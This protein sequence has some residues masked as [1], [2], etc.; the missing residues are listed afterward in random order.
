LIA[1][2]L[3]SV[4]PASAASHG[5]NHPIHNASQRYLYVA[6]GGSGTID[7]L[8]ISPSGKV[9]PI[10][11]APFKLDTPLLPP[12]PGGI[13]GPFS[14]GVTP[15]GRYLYTA[16]FMS[17]NVSGFKVAANGGLSPVPG[18]PFSMKGISDV[19]VIS[20]NGRHV[21]VDTGTQIEGF[22]IAPNGS[23]V[24]PAFT[25]VP[26]DGG[27][28]GHQISI[29][30]DGRHVFASN[31]FANTITTYAVNGAGELTRTSAIPTVSV[32]QLASIT[33]DSRYMYVGGEG[34]NSVAG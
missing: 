28:Y 25:S 15:N 19:L 20:P 4:V 11:G 9:T 18:S 17:Q 8:A 24:R 16:N 5:A 6:R 21:Y 3:A 32:P 33:P 14:I 31:F 34:D 29:A 10:P 2:T 30:P 26:A 12:P 22:R 1:S 13:N 7:A 23:L 27:A